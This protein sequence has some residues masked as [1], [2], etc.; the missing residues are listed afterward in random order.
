MKTGKSPVLV[1]TILAAIA[2]IAIPR[3]FA[4]APAHRAVAHPIPQP[5]SESA[6]IIFDHYIK[7][8]TALAQDSLEGVAESAVTIAKAVRSDPARTFAFRVANRADL[9]ARAKKL[10]QARAALVRLTFPL[11]EY[12][13]KSHLAGFYEGWCP[14]Q[15]TRLLPTMDGT[16][17]R[18]VITCGKHVRYS[19]RLAL[20]SHY[21][22]TQSRK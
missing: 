13:K 3:A 9:L 12:A 6:Q 22:L 15:R 21:S 16:P 14:M 11:S 20:G 2:L 10:T 17:I 5:P 1:V 7:I 4:R 8:Q 18:T 19:K